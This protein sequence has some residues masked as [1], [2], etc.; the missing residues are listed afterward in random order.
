MRAYFFNQRLNTKSLFDVGSLN[1]LGKL[2]QREIGKHDSVLDLGCGTIQATFD[3]VLLLDV[4]EHL[5]RDKAEQLQR[6]NFCA[7]NRKLR[8][9]RKL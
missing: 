6:V 2:V 3:I 5:E 8:D 1:W 9:W 7:W 4:V